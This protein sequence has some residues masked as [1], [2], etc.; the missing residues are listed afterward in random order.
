MHAPPPDEDTVTTTDTH[1]PDQLVLQTSAGDYPLHEYRRRVQDDE[2]SI[3]H[4]GAILTIADESRFLSE[5]ESRQPYGVVLWPAAIALAHDI[6]ARREQ[7]AGA[8]VL[9]LGAGTGLPGIVAATLGARVIQTD[10]HEGALTVCRRNASRHG[11]PQIEHRVVDWSDCALDERFAWII[12]SD[13]AYASAMHPALRRL[14]DTLLAPGGHVLLADPFRRPSLPLLEA[15]EGDGW[16]VGL[17]KWSVEVESGQ[18]L[19]GVY[20]LARREPG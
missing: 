5:G 7:F 8:R 1:A 4:T 12:G 3:L 16:S 13:I 2:W 17:S 11:V 6:V 14:F 15:L 9:E 18:R 20:E 19:I 10:R